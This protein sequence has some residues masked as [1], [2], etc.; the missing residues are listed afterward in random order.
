MAT[1]MT[2]HMPSLCLLSE[3]TG[4]CSSTTMSG[5][6]RDGFRNGF[7]LSFAISSGPGAWLHFSSYRLS[8]ELINEYILLFRNQS[9]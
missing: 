1:I 6:L 2:T 7:G 3:M 4:E 8:L 9:I 5:T